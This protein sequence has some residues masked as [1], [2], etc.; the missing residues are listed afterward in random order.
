MA[1]FDL[2][3]E[4]DFFSEEKKAKPEKPL[5]EKPQP[6]ED[7]FTQPEQEDIF[8]ADELTETPDI[9]LPEESAEPA[10]DFSEDLDDNFDFSDSLSEDADQDE[11][12]P[13]PTPTPK[14]EIDL[15]QPVED[16]PETDQ[17]RKESYEMSD[18]YDEKQSKINY[19]PFV[20]GALALIAVV[21]LFFVGKSYLFDGSDSAALEAEQ[22]AAQPAAETAGPS[23]EELRRTNFFSNLAAKT[24]QTTSDLSGISGAAMKQAFKIKKRRETPPF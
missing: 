16:E 21:V 23:P 18:Y 2:I 7:L 14:P 1:N 5:P 4:D 8:S 6:E 17:M 15:E 20:W 9:N 19:K 22:K 12:A 24:N 10:H 3:S 11:A 13:A